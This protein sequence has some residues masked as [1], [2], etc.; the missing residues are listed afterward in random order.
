LTRL[1][2][3]VEERTT[4]SITEVARAFGVSVQA[5]HQWL[6]S[7]KLRRHSRTSAKGRYRIP[8]AEFVRLLRESGRP[9]QGLWE[10]GSVPRLRL[11]F[12]DD[13]RAIRKLVNDFSECHW[14]PLE[15]RTAPNV[16]DGIVLASQFVPDI[17]FLDYF[18]ADD[19]LRG[20]HALTFIRGAKAMRKVRV[21][22]MSSDP[23][24]GRKMEE[25]GADGFLRK[26][27]TLAALKETILEHGR[28]R[29]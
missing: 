8:R 17:I 10:G 20:D 22:G 15:A 14:I 19:R 3:T 11:L 9:V 5:V 6:R 23:R 12:I 7:G 18:F 25:A 16:E 27:F 2:P 26:P 13:D 1:F 29:K 21:V 24:L 28:V 4:F